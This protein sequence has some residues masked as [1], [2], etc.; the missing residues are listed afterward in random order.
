MTNVVK[1]LN[2]LRKSG[3]GL[4]G[5]ITKLQ[6]LLNAVKMMVMAVLDDGGNDETKY[7]VVRPNVMETNIKG[8]SENL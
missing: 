4:S 2:E 1:F 6:T 3:V 7:V 5:Q 8:I